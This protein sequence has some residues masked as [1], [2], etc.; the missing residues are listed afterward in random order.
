M[1]TIKEAW[2]KAMKAPNW[3][4]KAELRRFALAVLDECEL[5]FYGEE[6]DGETSHAHDLH[7]PIRARI[8]ERR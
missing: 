6:Y 8:E 3:E 5:L 7:A 1:T 2:D 4:T